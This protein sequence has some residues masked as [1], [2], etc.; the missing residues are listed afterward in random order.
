ML[1]SRS[2]Q[3]LK[4]NSIYKSNPD[5]GLGLGRDEKLFD[6]DSVRAILFATTKI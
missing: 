4:P 1:L 2:L 5:L 6:Q 3:T